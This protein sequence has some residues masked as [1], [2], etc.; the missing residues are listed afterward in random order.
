ME[1]IQLTYPAHARVLF[2]PRNGRFN[3]VNVRPQVTPIGSSACS[4]RSL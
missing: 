3:H 4:G 2:H 1:V